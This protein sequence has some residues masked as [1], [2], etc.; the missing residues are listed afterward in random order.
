MKYCGR[1]FSDTEIAEIR[2]IVGQDPSRTRWALSQLICEALAWRKPDGGLKEMSCRVALLRMEKHGLVRLPPPR[3]RNGNGK[4][5][6]RRTPRGEP[7]PPVCTPVSELRDLRLQLVASEG[8]SRLWNEYIDRYHYLGYKP[9]PG[10]QLRYFACADGHILALLGFGA[11]AWKTAPRDEFIGW[12]RAQRESH[13]HLVV[14]NARFLILPWVTSKHL[15]SKLLGLAAR[16]LPA[17]WQARYG[18]R[19]LILETFVEKERF[20][21][22]SY[23]AANWLCLGDTQGRGKLDRHRLH[24]LPLKSVWAFP[25]TPRFRRLLTE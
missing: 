1:D 16:R 5:C 3:R 8:D 21:G 4:H 2:R 15:A 6:V 13:L 17:D 12:T 23:R 7:Q 11:A 14:N 25:L 24:A 20:S 22:T 19:P 10:A 9:L 18:Y